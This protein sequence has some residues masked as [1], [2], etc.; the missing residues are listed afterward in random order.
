VNKESVT[1]DI[2]GSTKLTPEEQIFTDPPI[3]TFDDLPSVI[4]AIPIYD[5][6]QQVLSNGQGSDDLKFALTIAL[7]QHDIKNKP[8]SGDYSN[9]YR[10]GDKFYRSCQT[11]CVKHPD[12]IQKLIDLMINRIKSIN[13]DGDG[14]EKIKGEPPRNRDIPK[15]CRISQALRLH[16]WQ[17]SNGIIEFANIPLD[18]DDYNIER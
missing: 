9:K 8:N 12:L 6:F 14:D 11:F 17:C 10:F 2:N 15:R 5:Y 13:P 16:Y 1:G 4:L 18:H 3:K 7:K